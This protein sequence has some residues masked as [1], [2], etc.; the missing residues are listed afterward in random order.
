VQL[1][2]NIPVWGTPDE[3]AL[4]QIKTCAKTADKVA[5]M[6]DH[7]KGYAVP[8]GGVVAYKNAVSPSGV[9]YDIGCGNKAVLLD[10]PGSELRKNIGKIMDDVFRTISFGIGRSNEEA[11]DHPLFDSP[12][13]SESNSGP[14]AAVITTWICLPMN[15]TA[16]GLAF[17]LARVV[18]AIKLPLGF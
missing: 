13:W 11:V 4:N 10:I 2:E 17:T 16:C 9:G 12:A 3:G 15:K 8:I 1:I 14:W 7:H 18:S 5:L 6:A